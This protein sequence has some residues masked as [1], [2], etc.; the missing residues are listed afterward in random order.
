ME[1]KSYGEYLKSLREGKGLN[2][3][4]LGEKLEIK[5]E[6]IKRWEANLE[7]PTLDE[8]YKLSEFYE[9]PCEHLLRL[10][11][12]LFKPNLKLVRAIAYAF[13][14]SIQAAIAL[15]ILFYVALIV[16]AFALFKYSYDYV[17]ESGTFNNVPH[18]VGEFVN[19]YQK[20]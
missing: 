8:M 19:E 20:R 11:D 10:K 16:G 5:I 17:E 9:I 2:V 13:G 7:V 6:T 4:E 12:D 15:L 18:N 3:A 1:Y 14:I